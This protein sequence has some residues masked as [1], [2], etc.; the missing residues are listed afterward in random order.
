VYVK[1][2]KCTKPVRLIF[3]DHSQ[4]F[5]RRGVEDSS[6]GGYEG[7]DGLAKDDWVE[8]QGQDSEMPECPEGFISCLFLYD[9]QEPTWQH[10][11][12][13]SIA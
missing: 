13:Y 11:S 5:L 9:V 7:L 12:I 8:L 1:S 2:L 3:I 4:G 6:R 10:K